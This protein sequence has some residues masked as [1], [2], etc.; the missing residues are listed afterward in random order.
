MIY[1]QALGATVLFPSGG[2]LGTSTIPSNGQVPIGTATGIYKPTTPSW[3]TLLS[4]SGTGLISYNSSTGVI[5]FTG[6]IPTSTAGITNNSGF[7][8]LGSLAG[9]S[10]IT[11]NSGTGHIGFT[12]PGYIFKTDLSGTAPITFNTSTG[13]IGF[14]NPGY[15]TGI[16]LGGVSSSTFP[17]QSPLSVSAT[18]TL[19]FTNPGYQTTSTGLTTGNFATTSISQWNNDAS[20]ATGTIYASSTWLKVAN[21]GSDINSTSSFRTALGLGTAATADTSTAVWNAAK[22]QGNPIDSS[23]ASSGDLLQYGTSTWGHVTTSSFGALF[24]ADNLAGLNNTSTSRTNLGLGSIATL[25]SPLPLANGGTATTTAFGA[26]SNLGI[27]DEIPFIL[28]NPTAVEDDDFYLVDTTGTLKFVTLV[29]KT[30]GDTVTFNLGWASSR[31][32]A[33]TTAQKAFTSYQTVT[34]TTTPMCFAVTT[35]TACPN[36]I[37]GST[38]IPAWYPIRFLT[39]GASSSQMT[40]TFHYT[41]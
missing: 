34:A 4:L 19:V 22:L 38:T 18:G 11:Y 2:G 39:Q 36:S 35:S 40:M 15:I 12:N 31:A 17:V 25:A 6:V 7:I 8:T 37:T 3:I 10:P 16:T 9:D 33:T 14:I 32:T 29:N 13:A 23:A 5:S 27:R 28:E 26:R 20:Y 1:G 24:K 41:Y 21:N 30:A